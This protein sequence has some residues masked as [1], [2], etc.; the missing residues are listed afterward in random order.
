MTETAHKTYEAFLD[1]VAAGQ[2]QNVKLALGW[3]GGSVEMLKT[4]AEINLRVLEAVTEQSRRQQE[5]SRT[6]VSESVKTFVDLSYLPHAAEPVAEPETEGNGSLPIEDFDRLS[7]EE[8]IRRLRELDAREV[9][10]IKTYEKRHKNR[11][12]ILERLDRTL[13]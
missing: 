2:A 4:Q 12:V 13:V 9:E 5:V 11:A 3:I 7:V 8:I 10:E 6:L 1:A